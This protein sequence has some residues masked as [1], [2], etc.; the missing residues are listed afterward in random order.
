MGSHIWSFLAEMEGF[1]HLWRPREFTVS[2]HKSE[3]YR[4]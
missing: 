1:G 4:Q 2:S 3:G